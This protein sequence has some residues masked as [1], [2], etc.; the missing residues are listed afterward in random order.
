M[1]LAAKNFYALSI[2]CVVFG[3][4]FA[5]AYVLI[6]KIAELIVGVDNFASAIGLNFFMQGLGLL[7]GTPFASWIFGMSER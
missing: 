5:S 6:P 2:L 3:F 7:V 1:P 4:T